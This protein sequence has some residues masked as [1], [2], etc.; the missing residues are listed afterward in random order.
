MLAPGG[1][2]RP[3]EVIDMTGENDAYAPS[4]RSAD[5]EPGRDGSVKRQAGSSGNAVVDLTQEENRD[6]PAVEISE[7]RRVSHSNSLPL[8]SAARPRPR[9]T[10]Q[11]EK[12]RAYIQTLSPD[13]K[14]VAIR[15]VKMLQ[16]EKQSLFNRK[17]AASNDLA[18]A[19][20]QGNKFA[21]QAFHQLWL[22]HSRAQLDLS[23]MVEQICNGTVANLGE[24]EKVAQQY[25]A[26]SRQQDQ[27]VR[28][29][30]MLQRSAQAQSEFGRIQLANDPVYQQGRAESY[31][32]DQPPPQSGYQPSVS[33]GQS[34]VRGIGTLNGNLAQALNQVQQPRMPTMPQNPARRPLAGVI[35]LPSPSELRRNGNLG[36]GLDMIGNGS[37]SGIG[38][39]G[40][41]V[42]SIYDN[43]VN[44]QDYEELVEQARKDADPADMPKELKVD[45]WEHQRLGLGWLLRAELSRNRGGILADDMGLG[46]TVQTIALM[47]SN[48][49]KTG[50][51]KQTLI[52]C[53][54]ALLENWKTELEKR[55][56]P[57][58]RYRVYIH[59]RATQTNHHAKFYTE[60]RDIQDQFDV[61]IA[62]YSAVTAEYKNFKS[63]EGESPLFDIEW[64][65]IV[66]DEAH[67]IK[68]RQSK[69]SLACA[70]LRSVYRLCL[71]GTPMQNDPAELYPLVRF[72]HIEPYWQ[73]WSRFKKL[74]PSL[75][76]P[77][78]VQAEGRIALVALLSAIMLRRKKDTVINGK[79]ILDTLP[80]KTQQDIYVRLEGEELEAYKTLEG[81][82]Q[83]QASRLMKLASENAYSNMLVLLLR[84]RQQACH[85]LLIEVTKRNRVRTTSFKDPKKEIRAAKRMDLSRRAMALRE[86]KGSNGV[87]CSVCQDAMCILPHETFVLTECGH[88]CCHECANKFEEGLEDD[89]D[90]GQ[91]C[92]IPEC[93][94]PVTGWT[95]VEVLDAVSPEQA[96]NDNLITADLRMRHRIRQSDDRAKADARKKALTQ[97]IHQQECKDMWEQGFGSDEEGEDSKPQ[98]LSPEQS[99]GLHNVLDINRVAELFYVPDVF[100]T[101]WVTS[102]KVDKCME[103]LNGIWKQH[104]EDKVIVFSFFTS[105]LSLMTIPLEATR[106]PYLE[107]NGALS[108]PERSDV[109]AKFRNTRARV[110]LTSVKAGN[111]GLTLT[112]AN[113]V[114]IMDPYWNPYVEEQAKDRVY[115]IGQSKPVTI[116]RVLVEDSVENRIID[117]QAKKMEVIEGCLDPEQKRRAQGLNRNDLLYALGLRR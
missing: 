52:I 41:P 94:K 107:Y 16:D 23:D 5:E 70:H 32:S 117:L 96:R 93:N 106:V 51:Q 80:A 30:V 56:R 98:K 25:I 1:T 58:F 45:F 28:Q 55:V 101:G 73:D 108:A 112:E 69:G 17:T 11:R 27:H 105:M 63:H 57:E 13:D 72:L 49:P 9:Q 104:P 37:G 20:Q 8:A 43:R 109:L 50:R 116:Y 65:R 99:E 79:K 95:C 39:Y 102:A 64:Y 103:V 86:F 61:V 85:P 15:L 54:V 48:P 22:S 60:A 76:S 29:R 2:P 46:K 90:E 91:R 19:K 71:T 7:V 26:A 59:H 81:T 6:D 36:L 44:L 38:F 77:R 88:F 67:T 18:D 68:N 66:L 47:Y 113:H 4:K 78:S 21:E 40:R 42:S 84:L 114:I 89:D 83:A 14:K 35:P 111:V 24:Q 100:S 97:L 87:G 115:R 33:G 10:A 53:P 62:T 31:V 3:V 75:D 110:L 12:L 82:I 92:R 34:Q 74:V